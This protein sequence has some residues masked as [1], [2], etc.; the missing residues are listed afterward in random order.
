MVVFHRFY[1]VAVEIIS[2]VIVGLE[3]GRRRTERSHPPPRFRIEQVPM[4]FTFYEKI[5]WLTIFR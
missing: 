5:V 3:T 4:R 1:Y 2:R